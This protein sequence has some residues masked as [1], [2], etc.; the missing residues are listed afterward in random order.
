MPVLPKLV[1]ENGLNNLGV[2]S[3]LYLTKKNQDFFAGIFEKNKALYLVIKI[4]VTTYVSLE[5]S[6]QKIEALLR[7]KISLMKLMH[8]SEKLNVII[9][10]SDSH[11]IPSKAYWTLLTLYMELMN[12]IF[13]VPNAYYYW[14]EFKYSLKR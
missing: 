5:V 9:Q 14:N 8:Q 10:E 4:K 6:Q 1:M 2:L 13:T 3:T 12:R 11:K 7:G